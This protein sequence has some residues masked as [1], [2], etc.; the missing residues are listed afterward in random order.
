MND[1]KDSGTGFGLGSQPQDRPKFEGFGFDEPTRQLTPVPERPRSP[2]LARLG[3]VLLYIALAVGA[4]VIGMLLANFIIMP[5]LVGGEEIP[6]PDLTNMSFEAATAM[7]V[8]MGL[9]YEKVAEEYSA[10][11]PTG[12]VVSQRQEPG[13]NVRPGRII[14]LTVSAGSED[15]RV[16]NVTKMSQRQAEDVLRRAGLVVGKVRESYDPSVPESS[17]IGQNPEPG[18]EVPRGTRID[19][20]VSLGSE[21]TT[22][23]MPNL[24]G[25]DYRT[26]VS[27]VS[28]WELAMGDTTFEF[29][30]SIPPG[31]VIRQSPEVGATVRR[32]DTVTVAISKGPPTGGETVPTPEG[33][34]GT[35]PPDTF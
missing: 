9:N 26:A 23:K 16:P 20:L 28:T 2:K 18:R 22:F 15:V 4:L 14:E 21:E 19:L 34:G 32:G 31:H 17:V 3:A 25:A 6:V 30:T 8:E 12:Y 35:P 13:M 29:S 1:Q 33:G 11:V 7:L 10:D 27:R 5:L 24:V